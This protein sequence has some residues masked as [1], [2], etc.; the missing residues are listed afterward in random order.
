MEDPKLVERAAFV[1]TQFSGA[2]PS[3][4]E[5]LIT[6]KIED[7]LHVIDEIKELRS[8]SQEGFSAISIELRDDVFDAEE[9]WSELR[10][11]LDDVS[12]QL[13]AGAAK[14][15]YME[16]DFKAF[17]ML[18]A[19]SWESKS[20][21]NFALLRRWARQLESRLRNVTGTEKVRLF[22]QPAE[23]IQVLLDAQ[24]ATA[25][26]LSFENI[27]QQI[28]QSDSK[29]SAGLVRGPNAELLIEVAGELTSL[30]RIEQIPI[31]YGG[32][33][34]F[35][36]LGDLAQIRKTITTPPTSMAL[37]SGKPAIVLGLF[38]RPNHRIDTWSAEIF[39]SLDEFQ[40]LLPGG[41]RLE[42]VFDQ[43][44]YVQAR[45]RSLLANLLIGGV[46]VFCVIWLMMGWRNAISVA[47]ALPLA[48]LMVLSGMRLFS[49]PIH[50][51]SITGLI[52]ALGLL[53][54]N[55][56]VMVD[57][58]SAKMAKGF[59][60]VQAVSD[61][62]R[63]LFV[64]LFG[65]TLTT[66]LAFGPIAL[67]PGPAGEFVGSIA[68]NVIVAIFSS[69]FLAMTIVPAV[70]AWFHASA[71]AVPGDSPF[72]AIR[73]CLRNGVES[74]TLANRYRAFLTYL[75]QR[76]L[77]GSAISV[78]IPLVGFIQA[79]NLPEQFFPP[80]DRDQLHIEI[81][82]GPQA[83]VTGSMRLAKQVRAE[84]LRHAN[85]R[86]VDWFVGESAPTFY[87]NLIARKR[88]T[89][90]YAQAI[91]QL[92][93]ADGIAEVIRKFQVELDEK[94]PQA[95][96]LVRQLEQGPPFDAPIEVRIFGPDLD[97]LK[98]IGN[99]VRRILV[100]TP[101]VIHTRAELDDVLPK[102]ELQVSEENA[103][104]SGLDL[105][106]IARQLDGWTEGIVGGSIV[107]A[108]E[109]LPVRVR[110]T[111]PVR[112]NLSALASVDLVAS[113]NDRLNANP[114]VKRDAA[115]SD[116]YPGVP[117]SALADVQLQADF[118]SI[119]HL[120][121]RRMNEI[122]VFIP[123]GVLPSKVLSQFEQRLQAA[124][125]ELPPGYAIHFG[126]EAAK[127]DEAIGNLMASVGVLLVL[128][129]ATLVLS[130]GSFRLACLIGAVGVLSVGL[131]LGS[132]WL[133]GY[134]F[135]FMAI[136][137]TMG[138]IG[139]AI[140]DSI[141]V[142]AAIKG[143][144]AARAGDCQAIVDE[145]CSTTRHVI[146]TTLT[147]MAGFTPL[148]LAG[149][150]FWPPLAIAIAGGVAGATLLALI[151]VPTAYLIVKRPTKNQLQYSS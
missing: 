129:V 52:I 96:V 144:P 82:L 134:P 136:V 80:A 98:R 64:P 9:V 22:G 113:T 74:S 127:R 101:G 139:V 55:A 8:S 90:Q 130:F 49:I 122:Q 40:R 13:P 109:E 94:F 141:V 151:F 39:A 92:D 75:L 27:S 121:G 12:N 142:L 104:A 31:R 137:G 77:W 62:V 128:M 115:S 72:S 60:S 28:E 24:T 84:L 108:T 105:S 89:S 63:R 48:S 29:I 133:F 33:G 124:K 125:V 126:G 51:M 19:I 17:A 88:N 107:E 86:R 114:G 36:R 34:Q 73:S 3:R 42:M 99:E 7:E 43:N 131:G 11:H 45:L 76:P 97:A 66:A 87:Y 1:N 110:L 44:R 145:V 16:I 140:N 14:P 143:N 85:V 26:N 46:A 150:G 56:I 20:E 25:L 41:I 57:E 53:I 15:E 100:D 71:T 18:V 38:V 37:V 35:A 65:S 117:F 4:V 102:I 69:L 5:S 149:G 21:P 91:V 2:D 116:Q 146:S 148:I 135:G 10:D 93:S 106:S 47:I 67:M 123:A 111:D 68:I 103:R 81:E 120:A 32:E 83:S 61:T 118:G 6:D 78:I 58:V 70:A 79:R 54:D 138:L 23:E 59:T 119:P 30:Q 112:N 147:T 50:Q 132:L 95:R